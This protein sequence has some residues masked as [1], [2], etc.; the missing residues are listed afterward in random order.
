MKL[1]RHAPPRYK[2]T[3][4][5]M[6]GAAVGNG[7]WDIGVMLSQLNQLKGLQSQGDLGKR[8]RAVEENG[9][10]KGASGA[11]ESLLLANVG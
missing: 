9:T 8:V 11:S 7:V 2:A 5:G 4:L 10:S 6:L 1:F 3:L